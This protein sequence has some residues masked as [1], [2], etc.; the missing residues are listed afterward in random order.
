VLIARSKPFIDGKSSIGPT[1]E[2]GVALI[3]G[4]VSVTE[5]ESFFAPVL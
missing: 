1:I 5:G 3:G 2:A 4:F